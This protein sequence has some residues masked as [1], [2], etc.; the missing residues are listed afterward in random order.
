MESEARAFVDRLTARVHPLLTEYA[1]A[2]WNLA[3]RGTSEDRAALERIGAAYTRLFTE[4]S[5]EWTTIQRLYQGRAAIDDELLRRQVERLYHMYASEQI[6]PEHIDRIAALEAA[7]S[8]LY[9]NFRGSLD[10]RPVSDNEIKTILRE[11]TD[12]EVRRAAWEASKQIGAA[13][14]DQLLELVALRNQNARALGFRD[15]YAQA[16]NLQEIDEA[17]LFALLEDLELRTREPFRVLKARLDAALAARCGVRTAQLR[18]WHYSDPFFQEAP[19]ADVVDLDGLFADQDIVALATRTYDGIGLEVRDILARS[20]LYE[21]AHKDQHAFCLHIDRTTDDV[22]VLCNIRPDARWMETLLHELGHGVYDKY[23]AADLPLLLR[24]PAHTNTTEAVAMLMGRLVHDPDWL[25]L[26]RGLPADTVA[27]LAGAAREQQRIKQFVFVRWALVM[28]YFERDL[29]ADPTRPDLNQRWWEYVERFQMVPRPEGR[30]APD[31]A[32]KY[33]LAGAPVYYHNYI[34]GE[35]TASQLAHA[36]TTQVPGARLVDNPETG[37]FLRER[38]FV[39]GARFPWN[40]ML[41]RATG[42]RLNPQ[43]YVQEFVA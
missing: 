16:L 15:Y 3:T 9:T 21:R 40:E 39:H 26:V 41:E 4:D 30:D 34:L 24:Y 20:D 27:D 23:L 32:A 5:A 25:A 22:R 35:L 1:Q 10:G 6:A 43:Y 14:C 33:H 29:Y 19:R 28:V 11:E 2:R 7:L 38:L 42:E 8:D 37:R 18:P 13:A 31:W 36:I 17:E 12:S